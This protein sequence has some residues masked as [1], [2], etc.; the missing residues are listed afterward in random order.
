MWRGCWTHANEQCAK[1]NGSGCHASSAPEQEHHGDP[2][3]ILRSK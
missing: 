1:D 2:S 3:L